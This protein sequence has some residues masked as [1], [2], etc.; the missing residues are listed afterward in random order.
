MLSTAIVIVINLI[1][2]LFQSL[3]VRWAAQRVGSSKRK[4]RYGFFASILFLA[5]SAICLVILG[6]ATLPE[7]DVRE[8]LRY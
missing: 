1:A 4:L 6:L 5:I 3:L 2:I 8:S 7:V